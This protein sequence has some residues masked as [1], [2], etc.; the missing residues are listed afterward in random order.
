[1]VRTKNITELMPADL[2]ACHALT[3]GCRRIPHHCTATLSDPSRA[4]FSFTLPR[5]PCVPAS[6]LASP[7]PP[8][9][10]GCGGGVCPLGLLA[11]LALALTTFRNPAS[12]G[13]PS[14][15]HVFLSPTCFPQPYMF[16]SS[17][18]TSLSL[19]KVFR[20]L[21]VLLILFFDQNFRT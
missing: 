18:P 13:N 1:M 7:P 19:S 6:F 11:S 5:V 8:S 4:W 9:L 20:T 21:A 2:R 14:A 15:L 12:F 16:S 10:Q 3:L 17:S